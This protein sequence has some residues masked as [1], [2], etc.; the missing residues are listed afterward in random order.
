[1]GFEAEAKRWF[2][3]GSIDFWRNKSECISMIWHQYVQKSKTWSF[4]QQWATVENKKA[5]PKPGLNRGA[6]HQGCRDRSAD[7]ESDVGALCICC[8]WIYCR[9]KV[10]VCGLCLYPPLAAKGS[11]VA[12]TWLLWKSANSSKPLTLFGVL[13]G[14]SVEICDRCVC[15]RG[16]M[17]QL[18]PQTES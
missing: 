3:W 1:M 7:T 4:S 13:Y 10:H 8:T 18:V 15:C 14:Q 17:T 12:A 16:I 5:C 6:V 2:V 11:C 9:P